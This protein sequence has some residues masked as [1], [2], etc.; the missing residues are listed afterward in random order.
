[1][2]VH[3]EPLNV[4][5]AVLDGQVRFGRREDRRLQIVQSKTWNVE[6][7]HCLLNQIHAFDFPLT[8]ANMAGRLQG[9]RQ[10]RQ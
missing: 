3:Q 6:T 1:M 5:N 7:R 2:A 9:L 4:H 10:V 8:H